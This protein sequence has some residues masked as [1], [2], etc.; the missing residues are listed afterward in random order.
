M[1]FASGQDGEKSGPLAINQGPYS[2]KRSLLPFPL[3]ARLDRGHRRVGHCSLSDANCGG[4]RP[5]WNQPSSRPLACQ[6]T[7][8]WNPDMADTEVVAAYR[9]NAANCVEMARGTAR[10]DDR[11]ALLEMARAWLRLAQITEKVGE[12]LPVAR[13]QPPRDS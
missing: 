3:T 4:D 6:R 7:G 5:S 10:F 12:A 9:L 11:I 2:L 8:W 1:F 13:Q